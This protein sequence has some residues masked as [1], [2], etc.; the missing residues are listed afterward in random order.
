MLALLA[1]LGMIGVF[2]L[3]AIAAG[4]LRVA[5]KDGGSPVLKG[6]STAP[7]TASSSPIP[8]GRVVYANAAYRALVDAVGRRCPPGRARLRRRSGRV[9]GGLPPAQGGAR[10]PPPAGGGAR[11]RPARRAGALAADCACVRS[12]TSGRRR[13]HDGVDRRRRHARTRA[14]GKR[15]PGAAARD[16]LSRSRAG[17]LLLGRCARQCRIP[18][19]DARR[20]ARLRSRRG[21]RRAASSSPTSS[22]G[23]GAALLTTIVGPARRGED[24]GPRSRSQD[25]RRQDAA[26]AALSQGR[27][28]RRRHARAIAHARAQ[29]RARRRRPTRSA[30]PKCGSCASSTTRR[31]RSRRVDKSG[32]IVRTNALFARLFRACSSGERQSEGRSSRRASLRA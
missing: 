11:R 32:K 12:A 6:S 22:P 8:T 25:A 17:R 9:G 7:P 29:P 19:R 2:S 1:V 4:I 23:D 20:L 18:Q 14:A 30:R 31:W 13:A 28:R 21:R 24:R 15:L 10:R 3:F 16:R 5:G 26:G 27:V